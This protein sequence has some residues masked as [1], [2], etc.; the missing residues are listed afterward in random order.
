M[1]A[2]SLKGNFSKF[3]AYYGYKLRTLR[4]MII[5][6]SI[7]SLLSYP[8]IFGIM[9]PTLNAQVEL[10]LY[11]AQ[12]G[13]GTA[14]Y[15]RLSAQSASWISLLT[16]ALVIGVIMLVAIFVMN[17][18]VTIKSFRWLYKK[19]VV[20]MDYSLP[21]SEDTRFC[22]DL[23]AVIT[24]CLVPHI[25]A[26]IAGVALCNG[27]TGV[28]IYADY[29]AML[30]SIVPQLMFTGFAASV[31]LIAFTLFVM[32][33]CGRGAEA[34]LYPAVINVIIPIIVAMCINIVISNVYGM[35]NAASGISSYTAAAFTSPLGLLGYTFAYALDSTAVLFGSGD[36]IF[37]APITKAGVLVP[38][39]L[40]TLALFAGAYL[41]IRRRHAERVGSPFV[42]GT[43]KLVVP[44]VVIFAFAA[45]FSI[46]IMSGLFGNANA[47]IN[48]YSYTESAGGYIVALIILTFVLYV[49]MELISGNG[50]KKFHITLLKY[51]VTLAGSFIICMGLY[52][53]NGMGMAYY[54]PDSSQVASASVSFCGGSGMWIN[55]DLRQPDNIKALT[56]VHAD[57]PKNGPETTSYEYRVYIDYTLKDGTTASRQYYVTEQRY[58]DICERLFSSELY[59]SSEA[60][61][62]LDKCTVKNSYISQI[63]VSSNPPLLCNIPAEQLVAALESDSKRVTPEMMY[64]A[65]ARGKAVSIGFGISKVVSE[66]I[67]DWNFEYIPVYPW[68]ADTLALL[69]DNGVT[70]LFSLDLSDYSCA[71]LL[72]MNP[73]LAQNDIDV[74]LYYLLTLDN[75]QA[76]DYIRAGYSYD[77]EKMEKEALEEIRYNY[78]QG[79]GGVVL[80]PQDKQLIGG[81]YDNSASAFDGSYPLDTVYR[82]VLCVAPCEYEGMVSYYV[83]ADYASR[84]AEIY[85]TCQ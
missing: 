81:L 39:I 19:S 83:S 23:L 16:A 12:Y 1:T 55:G 76:E 44:A 15:Q 5:L 9:L 85:K 4:S 61:R 84:A 41:L 37:A 56:E 54:V 28:E 50:F 20:D 31:M 33:L 7:F 10:E 77:Y 71:Y 35:S 63:L 60:G 25:I 13:Y 78:F 65:S 14:E 32:S 36:M 66:H 49:I 17:Y 29:V 69:A 68:Y 22:G 40:I 38:L 18:V 79:T 62:L 30:V 80:L 43:M 11:Y 45:V 42:Y 67:T 75:P 57:I 47:D 70:D 52:F 58:N 72:E 59:L 6:N 73:K 2:L 21:V 46:Y 82:L 34:R 24:T 53:S 27:M 51:V 8:L 26:I 74:G 48:S 64:N 3:G